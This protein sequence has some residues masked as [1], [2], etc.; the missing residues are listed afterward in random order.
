M[1]GPNSYHAT[2]SGSVGAAI[3]PSK[4]LPTGTIG[5]STPSDGI[6]SFIGGTPHGPEATGSTSSSGS[7][8]SAR[9]SGAKAGGAPVRT[10][11]GAASRGDC[12]AVGAEPCVVADG[13]PVDVTGE[14]SDGSDPGANAEADDVSPRR[15]P[16]IATAP[17][18][19]A[20]RRDRLTSVKPRP[21]VS[22]Q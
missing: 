7:V 12:P 6:D 20:W 18:T 2:V 4:S 8:S 3:P 16:P 15:S 10:S 1:P 11:G 22:Q 17:R 9:S 19:R 21:P 14:S 13:A 5:A